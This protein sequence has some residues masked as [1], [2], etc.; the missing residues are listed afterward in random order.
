MIEEKKGDIDEILPLLPGKKEIT[1]QSW[2]TPLLFLLEVDPYHMFAYW[3]VS[4]EEISVIMNQM[5]DLFHQSQLILRIYEGSDQKDF[6]LDIGSYF[7]IPVVGW[8]N[9]W[10][11]EIAKTDTPFYAEL[12][13][14]PAASREFFRITGSNVVR[15]SRT[16]MSSRE[17]EQWME[18]VGEYET[19]NTLNY[20]QMLFHRFPSTRKRFDQ[21]MIEEYY[22]NLSERG[23]GKD[24]AEMAEMIQMTA[25]GLEGGSEP[26][27]D[28]PISFP[29]PPADLLSAEGF[30]DP[31]GLSSFCPFPELADI[32]SSPTSLSSW[33]PGEQ[34]TS[35]PTFHYEADLVIYGRVQPG[36]ALYIDGDQVKAQ[37]DGTFSWR[38]NLSRQGDYKIPLKVILPGG[39]EIHESIPL[40][41]QKIKENRE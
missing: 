30:P 3:E 36:A 26:F 35:T 6:G 29:F 21:R 39:E 5:S 8:K 9:T 14:T 37:P 20:Q 22:L 12:G 34:I 2:M 4:S 13:L 18:V 32:S 33:L 17:G 19:V 11:L 31:L 24:V 7:D 23:W 1:F 41:F 28:D 15:T 25:G 16:E 38:L 10:Y 40:Y 27:R